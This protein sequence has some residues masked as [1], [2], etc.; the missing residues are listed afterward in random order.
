MKVH[1]TAF[2]EQIKEMGRELDSIITFGDTVLGAEELNAVTPSFQ[3]AILKS[4]MK[5][6][7]IDSNVEIPVGTTL[8]YKFGVKVDGQ[9]EYLDFGNYVVK[10]VERQ[11]DTLSYKIT[12]YDK[13]LYS[14]VDYLT[15][16]I[17][18]P[19]TITNYIDAICTFLGLS[20]ANKNDIFANYN[21]EI[22][23]ELYL[24]DEGNS[25]G[26]TF[27]DVFDELAQVTASTICINEN[28]EVEIRYI[29]DTEDTID[30]E[31][32]K[33]VNINFKEKFGEI[34]TIVLSRSADSD[35]IYY[36]ETLPSN[37]CEIKI[38]DNQIMNRN[39]R[40]D[41][42][43]DIYDKLNGL[44][45]YINDFVS[46][47]I[48]YYDLCDRYFV[49]IGN[50]T[51]PCIMFNDEVLVTQGLK[52]NIY[53]DMPEQSITDY[54]K[55]DKT[56][57]RVN[58]V[59]IIA[60]KQQK[61]ID[62]VVQTQEDLSGEIVDLGTKYSQTQ[63]DFRFQISG[64]E[65]TINSNNQNLQDEING[66]NSSLTNGVET[67]KNSLVTIN[68]NGIQVSTNTSK[69]SSIMQNNKFSIQ[70]NIGTDLIFVGYDESEGRSKAEMDNLTV[71]NY[72]TAGYHRQE[73]FELDG[74]KRT[75]WF[76]V[77]GDI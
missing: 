35:N 31:F 62:S 6:L 25:L 29:N 47:G 70:D 66:I 63:E 12:C 49:K 77:G 41:F 73:K 40:V 71:K 8:N 4:V 3:G 17:T 53:T 59:Y 5:Q 20:F 76:H 67:L 42:L 13:M 9:Y 55:A 34:N 10:D 30:E 64:L 14:M 48:C 37:P 22:P 56:D 11:E 60:D 54:T 27:R 72:F 44:Q 15:M 74:E 18:Y 7:D 61:R 45:F 1:T 2:K 19:I 69:I 38:S 32:L 39:D 21:K 50:N 36:P 52:E 68:I 46:T 75:G 23:Y 33:D 24:D 26:Y 57:R 16:N 51:Y 65:E 28:D 58:Q 43:P